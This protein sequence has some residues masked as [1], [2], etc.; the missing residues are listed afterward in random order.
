MDQEEPKRN[1]P[2]PA[3]PKR[4]YVGPDYHK[5]KSKIRLIVICM[6]VLLLA[7]AGGTG[8]WYFKDYKSKKE[9]TATTQNT[10][11]KASAQISTTTK[12][13][14]SPNFYLT[15]SYP[16]DWTITD[17][18]GGQ[19]IVISPAMKLKNAAGQAASTSSLAGADTGSSI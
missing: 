1:L 4:E 13:Y 5:E 8:W 17:S 19:M 12:S 3:P 11:T 7:A 6:V 9:I 14:T 15:F 2:E 16:T 18:G 10:S